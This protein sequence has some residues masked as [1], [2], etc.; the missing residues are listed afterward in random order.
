MIMTLT[1]IT[2]IITA[3]EIAGYRKIAAVRI[4]EADQVTAGKPAKER[5]LKI[6]PL[7]ITAE[8]P[9]IM[10][11][12]NIRMTFRNVRRDMKDSTRRRK[13]SARV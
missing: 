9:D 3:E 8:N 1:A 6:A 10:P 13:K 11:I 4:I 12:G 5:A 2:G 7:G